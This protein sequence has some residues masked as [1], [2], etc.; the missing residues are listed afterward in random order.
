M[1]HSGEM[2]E[3]SNAAVL[4]TVE[5]HTSGGSNPSFSAKRNPQHLLWVFC[6]PKKTKLVCAF[7]GKQ[8]RQNSVKNLGFY[9]CTGFLFGDARSESLYAIF[10]LCFFL[11]NKKDKILLR[12]WVFM[13]ALDF[14]LGMHGVNPFMPFSICVFWGK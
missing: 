10:N 3:W 14:F 8:K 13:L 1:R 6:F 11:E 9:A 5:G 7:F 12:I 2:A 4:K